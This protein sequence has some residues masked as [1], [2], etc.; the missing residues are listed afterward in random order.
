M[1]ENDFRTEIKLVSDMISLL[2]YVME[3]LG[4]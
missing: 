4:I 1:I 2:K 3:A